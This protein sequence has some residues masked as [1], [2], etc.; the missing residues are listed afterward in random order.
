MNKS[1]LQLYVNPSIM[2]HLTMARSLRRLL[3]QKI[4]AHYELRVIDTVKETDQ[5]FQDQVFMIPTLIRKHP[6]PEKRI[7]G[8]LSDMQQVMD[9]LR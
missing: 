5:T 1:I 7:I 6:V 2:K 4:Y 9:L 8:D 3:K